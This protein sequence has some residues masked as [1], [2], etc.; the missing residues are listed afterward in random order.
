MPQEAR[1]VIL[2]FPCGSQARPNRGAKS[3]QLVWEGR[4]PVVNPGSPGKRRP[5]GP[6]TYTVEC[7]PAVN[8]AGSKC[9]TSPVFR[10]P[11]KYGSQRNPAFTVR[12]ELTFHESC[13]YMPK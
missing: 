6:F 8:R 3:F 13:P 12:W 9:D 10:D 1:T 4:L 7:T 11:P 2:P 5:A